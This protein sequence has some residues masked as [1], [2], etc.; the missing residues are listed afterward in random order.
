MFACRVLYDPRMRLSEIRRTRDIT[1]EQ[2]SALSGVDQSTISGIENGRQNPT[3]QLLKKLSDA[4]ECEIADLF[5]D[6]NE[7]EQLLISAFRAAT[8]DQK[9]MWLNLSRAVLTKEQP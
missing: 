8:P 2:L 4:L 9:S 6:R 7:A 1:Q 3:V 5:A